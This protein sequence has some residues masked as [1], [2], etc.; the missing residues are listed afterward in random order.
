MTGQESVR[1][2]SSAHPSDRRSAMWVLAAAGLLATAAAG[3]ASGGGGG[4]NE[5]AAPLPPE[6]RNVLR[7]AGYQAVEMYNEA[8][9]GVRTLDVAAAT[10]WSV[11]GGVYAQMEIPVEQSDPRL[12]QL[13]TPGYA[14]R[15]IEGDR[16]NTFIDCGSNLAGP[17]ANQYDIT[18]SVVTRL[19][20]KGPES[21][22]ILTMI[23][24][25]GRPRAVSGNPIHCQSR[26]VLEQR[27]A[28]RI[29]EAL[30]KEP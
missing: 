28:Q 3:C 9:V 15:R 18:L 6:R 24:A 1:S 29:A 19:T 22:E 20:S 12:M 23:D 21:T 13:G 25:Y 8:G 4:S 7:V 14:A 17:M 10:V 16:M 5:D 26:G 2:R 27:V 11:V 30:G